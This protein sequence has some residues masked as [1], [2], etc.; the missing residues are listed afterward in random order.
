MCTYTES[1][2]VIYKVFF[3]FF[4]S[5]I[6]NVKEERTPIPNNQYLFFNCLKN[7]VTGFILAVLSFINYFK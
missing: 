2:F 4:L 3:L 7:N 1:F 6:T 5:K